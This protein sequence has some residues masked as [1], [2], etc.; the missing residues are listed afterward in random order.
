MPPKGEPSLL[1]DANSN[2][3]LGNVE[4]TP[5]EFTALRRLKDLHEKQDEI[6]LELKTVRISDLNNSTIEDLGN[7]GIFEGNWIE[8]LNYS[9]VSVELKT[10][11][12]SA[13][14]GFNIESSDDGVTVNHTHSFS[15]EAGTNHHYTFTLTG[16][17]YRVRYI[18]GVTPTTS[19]RIGSTLSKIDQSHQHTHGVEFVIDSDHPADLVRSVLT[20]KKP[21]GDYINI[22]STAGGNL[23]SAIEEYDDA[24]NPIRKNMEGGGKIVVGITAIEVTFVG[25]PTHSIIITADLDNT[26]LLYVGKSNV[27]TAGANAMTFL[28]AGE[29]VTIDYNDVDNAVYVVASIAS[30][31]FWKGVLL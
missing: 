5:E 28:E 17:Y 10:D 27:T 31:N 13:I 19:F 26:G 1:W 16:K 20:A 29:S 2:P 25:T 12:L 9:S 30:Q 4:D 8:N 3:V 11:Q 7:G 6:L 21:N 18:N 22:E 24:V 23:K 14:D 15:I